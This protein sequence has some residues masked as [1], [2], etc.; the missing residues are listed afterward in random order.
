[1]NRRQFTISALAAS[2]STLLPSRLLRAQTAPQSIDDFHI[3]LVDSLDH[4]FFSWPETLLHYPIAAT[5]A[6][7]FHGKQLLE[8][9]SNQPVPYQFLNLD[10]HPEIVFLASLAPGES[11]HYKLVSGAEAT[12]PTVVTERTDG[13]TIL[14]NTG[15]LQVR[16][17]ASQTVSGTAP[18]PIMQMSRGGDWFGASTLTLPNQT[19]TRIDTKPLAE[20]PIYTIYRVTYT[21]SANTTY[22]AE[23][24]ATA[25]FDFVRLYEDMEGL[26]PNPET[27]DMGLFEFR[28]TGVHFTHRQAP[29]NP[30]TTPVPGHESTL[31][32][33]V[34]PGH[35]YEDYPFERIDDPYI[36]THIGLLPAFVGDHEWVVEMNQYQPWPAMT[37][38]SSAN[39]WDERSGNAA[40]IFIDRNELWN[41]HEYAIWHAAPKLAVHF[42]YQD[43]LLTWRLP[44]GNGTRSSCFAFYD[45]AKDIAQMRQLEEFTAGVTSHDGRRYSAP[46]FLTSHILYLQNFYGTLD[47]NQVKDWVLTY[48]RDA[49]KPPLVFHNSTMRT[50]ADLKSLPQGISALAISGVRQNN[51]F[52]PGR[53]VDDWTSNVNRLY[54]GLTESQ[55]TRVTA[56]CLLMVYIQGGEAFMP[57]RQMLSG[58]PNFLAMGKFSLVGIPFLFPDH[59][60]TPYWLAEWDA[61]IE[62]N[63]RYHTRP[64]VNTWDSNGGRWTEAIGTYVWG[65]LQESVRAAYLYFT[66]DNRQHLANPRL[67]DLANWLLNALSA[68]FH[69]E[70]P[71]TMQYLDS[72]HDSHSWGIVPTN[73]K[74]R[75]IHSPIG[76]HSDRRNPPCELWALGYALRNYAPLTAEHIMF[77]AHPT[78]DS[79]ESRNRDRDPWRTVIYAH[80]ADDPAISGTRPG[81]K[82][83]K[84]TGFGIVL[85]A[86]VN[87]P[88]EL[89]VHLQQIDDGPNYRWGIAGEGACG[90]V[91]F[92]A[93]G[94]AYSFNGP[95][96]Q[97]DRPAQDT[98]FCTNFGVFKPMV[99][100]TVGQTVL[101]TETFAHHDGNAPGTFRSVGQNVLT[102]P[103]LDLGAAQ[104]AELLARKGP[105]TYS[106]PEYISRAALLVGADYFLL[107]DRQYNQNVAHRFSWFVRKGDDFPNLLPIRGLGGSFVSGGGAAQYTETHT[108]V[109]DG[110]WYDGTGDCLMLVTH[111]SGLTVDPTPYG[112]HIHG[113]N[114][115]DTI[116]CSAEPMAVDDPDFHA[117]GTIAVFRKRATTTELALLHGVRIGTGN[118]T[119]NVTSGSLAI[120][121]ILD[122][123]GNIQGRLQASGGP[124][125]FTL[126]APAGNRTYLNGSL[127]DGTTI[128]VPPGAHTWEYTKS[129]PTPNTPTILRTEHH[130]KSVHILATPSAGATK[131]SVEW[132][133][134]HGATWKPASATSA[135]P[136]L[137]LEHPT[138][139]KY[140]VRAIAENADHR[141]QPSDDYPVYPTNEPP[142]APDGLHIEATPQGLEVTWGEVLGA[143][144]YRLYANNKPI[145]TGLDRKQT[146]PT[147]SGTVTLTVAA[148]SG[149]GE[150]KPAVPRTYPDPYRYVVNETPDHRFRRALTAFD[151]SLHPNDGPA[152]YYPE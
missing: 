129:L 42:A 137:I 49:R 26:P 99:Y 15:K 128:T 44:V 90:V 20:G 70:S 86:A 16:I 130:P 2:A 149:L 96:D 48:P 60:H 136:T 40:G 69:G 79:M 28:W 138:P 93:N 63:T 75:R 11:R 10:N 73:A 82:S 65:F 105:D 120:A 119:L 147:P 23:I 37:V 34:I 9:T 150:S 18:G 107:Y 35:R 140:H 103:L 43:G 139:K 38:N 24:H 31:E 127:V 64:R 81:L 29:N 8:T 30:I 104:Y 45:H 126:T 7:A 53:T 66:I 152:R 142:T 111:R 132:S 46:L 144:A 112:A 101:A 51:G 133:E 115:D 17:P 110:R 114:I 72:L 3:D 52:G 32:P 88:D 74:P 85:R 135:T 148:I 102:A 98:D 58:H 123:N 80:P 145:Y 47:L 77:V 100:S 55:R 71:Q 56:T 41:D 54:A 50:P 6:E 108:N 13:N 19:I 92:Y 39:F 1:M 21:T 27:R 83:S 97:G 116:L 143:T 87:T 146:I 36:S 62:L 141:S 59:P 121:A 89:S 14:L 106:Y 124:A 151:D 25:G 84:Y 78:D 94:K 113:P 33:R 57:M 118:V 61:Y 95:E 125:T 68:P 91:Y 117:T 5:S 134:D 4:P 76:A 67:V 12:P 131:Y 22:A 122:R 109:T